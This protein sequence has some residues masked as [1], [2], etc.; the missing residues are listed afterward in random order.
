MKPL[1]WRAVYQDQVLSENWES[2]PDNL[3]AVIIYRNGIHRLIGADY[4]WLDGDSYGMIYDGSCCAAGYSWWK[5]GVKMDTKPPNNII[6]KSGLM[7]PDR[8]WRN[9]MEELRG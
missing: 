7:L 1:K 2:I 6:L 3:L 8:E 5:N 4:Y 9:F